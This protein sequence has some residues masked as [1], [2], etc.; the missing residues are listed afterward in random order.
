MTLTFNIELFYLVFLAWVVAFRLSKEPPNGWNVFY[1]G[2]FAIV[3]VIFL[4][5]ALCNYFALEFS[6]C[7]AVKF[8]TA[9]STKSFCEIIT[10]M[11]EKVKT[12]SKEMVE[13]I[14]KKWI[15]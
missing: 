8:F 2:I 13:L 5:E 15:K 1:Y 10:E 12:N 7:Q 14:L 3:G 4:G 9:I 11:L 6:V